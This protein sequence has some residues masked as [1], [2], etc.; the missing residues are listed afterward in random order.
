MYIYL[1][2]F[3]LRCITGTNE[4]SDRLKSISPGLI[5]K[6]SHVL[7]MSLDYF[8]GVE[9]VC[10]ASVCVKRDEPYPG[11]VAIAVSMEG[12]MACMLFIYIYTACTCFGA[13]LPLCQLYLQRAPATSIAKGKTILQISSSHGGKL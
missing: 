2:Q 1:S 7:V 5:S 11:N 4:T 12:K 6:A 10:C 3:R 13:Q 9:M 8:A